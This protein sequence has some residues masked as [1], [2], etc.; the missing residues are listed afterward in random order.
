[1]KTAA[2]A[3]TVAENMVGYSL[4]TKQSG[5]EGMM[6]NS[7]YLV[8]LLDIEKEMY[9]AFTL[10]R[11]AS[12]PCLVY[13]PAGGMAIE[14]VAESTPEL[15]FKAHVDV[16]KGFT[17]EQITEIVKNLGLQEHH[18]A[19]EKTLRNLYECFHKSDS[20]MI[21]I[22]PMVLAKKVGVL[23][24]DSKITI[25]DNAAYRQKELAEQEDK[26]N[27]TANER[28]AQKWDLN[29]I[30]IGGNIGCLV[31][32]AGLAMST[33]DILN[34]YDGKPANF[35]DVGGGAVGDQMI[36]AVN[37]LCDDPEVDTLYINIFGGILRCDLLVE[38]LLKAHEKNKF[39]KP[40]VMRLNGNKSEEAKKLIVGREVELGIQ[41]E[42]DFDTSAQL[43]VK[44]AEKARLSR[45]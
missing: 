25:D 3:K 40:I 29:Y 41:F 19:T 11:V 23:C 1:V 38:G 26:S 2:D 34:L 39:T 24:A 9:L 14:D 37:L 33:M 31:N 35:L 43:A 10:D 6:C 42:A 8:E 21:E 32:G 13:S 7:L 17:A 45:Q 30:P 22:N 18:A 36:A 27:D 12:A 44:T 4:V 5:P 16:D 28:I 20:D 15:I